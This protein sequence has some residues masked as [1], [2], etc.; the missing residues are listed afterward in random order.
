MSVP[1]KLGKSG[2]KEIVELPVAPDEQEGFQITTDLLKSDARI[3]EEVL[4]K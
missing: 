4:A 2:V 1:V 3:I